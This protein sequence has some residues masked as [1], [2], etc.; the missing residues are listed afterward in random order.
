[1]T[2]FITIA[3]LVGAVALAIRSLWQGR[4][5]GKSSCGG[6]CSSCGGCSACRP[7]QKS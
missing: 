2:Q 3:V 4:K 5:S 6:N 1:M 7:E